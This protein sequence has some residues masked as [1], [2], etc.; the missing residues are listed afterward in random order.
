LP[1]CFASISRILPKAFARLI[2]TEPGIG[3]RI[4]ES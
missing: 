1:G 2:L 3:Y 4:A